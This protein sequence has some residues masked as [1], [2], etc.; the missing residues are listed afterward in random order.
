MF[1]GTWDCATFDG[2]GRSRH[3]SR[4]GY[5]IPSLPPRVYVYEAEHV[6]S[7]SHQIY[8]NEAACVARVELE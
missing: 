2:L 7:M 8:W 1:I 3:L 4:S 5:Q 6:P